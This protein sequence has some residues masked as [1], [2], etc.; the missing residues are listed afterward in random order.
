VSL[1]NSVITING[2]LYD[3]PAANIT[4][5]NTVSCATT[6]FDGSEW[7]TQVPLAGSDEIFLSGLALQL[8]GGMAGGAKVNWSIDISTTDMPGVC[9][10]WK[11]GAAAYSAWPAG[12][13]YNAAQ[14][15]ATHNTCAYNNGDHAGTP[16]NSVVQKSVTG[17]ATGGGGSNYTGSWSSTKEV[18]PVCQ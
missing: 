16:E 10:K 14:I 15:K 5:T 17:G 12:P 11:W 3:V 2:I 1:T 6:M 18:C 7:Q 9:I 13:D 8:P 4:F